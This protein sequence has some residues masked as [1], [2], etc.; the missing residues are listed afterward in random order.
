MSSMYSVR[1]SQPTRFSSTLGCVCSDVV[2]C[3]CVHVCVCT[4]AC[5][6]VCIC[7]LTMPKYIFSLAK[8][9]LLFKIKLNVAT[10]GILRSGN[11]AL[12]TINE[13][14]EKL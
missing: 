1:P 4:C 14:L 10:E 13:T 7:A 11:W 2:V 12:D 8:V 6:C 5:A 3:V 9:E